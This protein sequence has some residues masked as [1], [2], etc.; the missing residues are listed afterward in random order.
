MNRGIAIVIACAACAGRPE[1]PIAN[2]HAIA[3]G[4]DE[5]AVSEA[6]FV[7][8]LDWLVSAGFHTVS[9]HD[10]AGYRE[11][12]TPL[13]S[14]TVILT[15]DDGTEDALTVVLPALQRRGFKATFFI[16]TGFVGK[17]GYLSWDGVRK[18]ADAG[19]EIGSH[20]VHHLRLPDLPEE[21]V[22]EE[23]V[24]SKADLESHLG[25]P[26]EIFAYPYNSARRHLRKS[27]MGAGYR[28]A[29]AGSAHG[30]RNLLHL[31][32]ITVKRD[33]TL[34]DFQRLVQQPRQ[35]GW[36]RLYQ[37]AAEERH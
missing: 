13:P 19:M 31:A 17:P 23:M 22:R 26:I 6:A 18:L 1:L 27:L 35:G 36:R 33:T 9:L 3:S 5:F 15:F 11:A 21:A 12:G 16:T 20:S 34:G 4:G 30:G 8:Q 32:R 14:R 25:A 28:I 2:Y 10:L 7:E 29:V 24:Q 37:R